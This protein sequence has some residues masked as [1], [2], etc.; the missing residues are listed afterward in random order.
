MLQL[1][2][3]NF[4]F[5]ER[6]QKSEGHVYSEIIFLFIFFIYKNYAERFQLNAMSLSKHI[7]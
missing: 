6:I 5:L 3:I 1:S 7:N 2:E 4:L